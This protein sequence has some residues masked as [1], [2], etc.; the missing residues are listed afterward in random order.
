MPSSK[1][2]AANRNY[3]QERATA[4]RRGETGAGSRSGDATRHRARRKK[5][6][7]KSSS[8]D[9]DHRKS[10]RSGG[11]NA[12][13]NLRLRSKSSNRAAGGRSGSRT[14][15]AA[16]ARKAHKAMRRR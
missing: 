10:L 12:K 9:V 14:G 16:G 11:S 8:K 15:K 3:R 1:K 7:G 4:K 6:G 5:L 2:Y 13:S